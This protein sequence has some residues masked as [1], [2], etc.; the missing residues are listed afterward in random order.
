MTRIRLGA[1]GG[2]GARSRHAA[3]VPGVFAAV[4]ALTSFP[5]GA[6]ALCA[7]CLGQNRA[8]TP[9]L[10]WLGFFLLVPFVVAYFVFRAVRNAC[11]D[12]Q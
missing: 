11:R 9:T 5:S 12:R 7:N 3:T 1:G 10:E 6:G 8:L 4:L 2:G